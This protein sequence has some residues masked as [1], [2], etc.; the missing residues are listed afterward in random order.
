MPSSHVPTAHTR[1]TKSPRFAP[2]ASNDAVSCAIRLPIFAAVEACLH[3]R[4]SCREIRT[5][6]ARF[7]CLNSSEIAASLA[8]RFEAHPHKT[9]TQLA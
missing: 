2:S 1:R 5:E 9:L 7:Y 8:R 6:V 4:A 3:M